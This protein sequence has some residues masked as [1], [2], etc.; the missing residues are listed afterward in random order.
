MIYSNSFILLLKV[1]SLFRSDL[2]SFLF[3]PPPLRS[4]PMMN[5][6]FPANFPN[7]QYQLLFTQDSGEAKE[8][9]ANGYRTLYLECSWQAFTLFLTDFPK[10]KSRDKFLLAR[11]AKG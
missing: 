8:G 4:S 2:G 6:F 7:K 3:S 10:V 5:K 9:K 11:L 1:R